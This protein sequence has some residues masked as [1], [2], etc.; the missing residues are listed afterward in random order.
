M[1]SDFLEI[2]S[3]ASFVTP[4]GK[5]RCF[6]D[7]PLCIKVDSSQSLD[8]HWNVGPWKALKL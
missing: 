2:P 1:I 5:L 4:E 3:K 6:A 7:N 8:Y